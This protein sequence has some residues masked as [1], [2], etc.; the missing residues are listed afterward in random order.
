[1]QSPAPA[2][3]P[4]QPANTFDGAL[5]ARSATIAAGANTE[6]HAPV[7]APAVMAQLMAGA[8]TDVTVPDP[9]PAPTMLATKPV[10]KVATTVAA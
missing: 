8:P 5:E 10:L 7:C 1:M 6:E 9:D 4:P 2:Q 3:S